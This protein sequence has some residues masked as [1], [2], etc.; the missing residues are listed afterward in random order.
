MRRIRIARP[1][2]NRRTETAAS[3]DLRSPSGR[4]LP[5]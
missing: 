5:Y 4:P 3:L 2:T 1:R